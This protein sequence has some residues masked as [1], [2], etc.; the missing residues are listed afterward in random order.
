MKLIFTTAFVLAV[1]AVNAQTNTL[2]TTGKIGIGT[3]NPTYNLQ[4]QKTSALSAIMI[5]G[6]FAGSPRLQVYGLDA[7]ANAWM[8]LGTD[9]SGG[10]YEHTIYFPKTTI[11]KGRLTIGD[12]NGTTYSTRMT[13]LENGNVGIGDPYPTYKLAVNGNI[14]AKEVKVE[15][16]NWPDYV[17]HKE[18]K[19]PTLSETENFIKSNGHL[20]DIPSAIDI[21]KNGQDLGEMNAKLLRKVEELTLYLIKKDKQL[22]LQRALIDKQSVD[23]ELQNKVIKEVLIDIKALKNKR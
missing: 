2:P 20:S 3:T 17:F 5:G 15:T 23:I 6:G 11:G 7:D 21:A 1:F 19:L 16:A 14:R 9:M 4:V 10:P 18:Y 8:G 22:T 12:Y 13:V